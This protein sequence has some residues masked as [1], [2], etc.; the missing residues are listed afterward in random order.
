MVVADGMGGQEGGQ[1]ASKLA[2]DTVREIFLSGPAE[3]PA[4][5]LEAAYHSAHSAIQQYARTHP[6]LAGMGTDV[7]NGN[8]SGLPRDVRAGWRF[9]VSNTYWLKKPA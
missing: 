5:V 1:I 7:H 6:E 2:V 4:G 9:P 3:D 8:S